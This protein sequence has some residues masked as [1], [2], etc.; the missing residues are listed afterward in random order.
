M[1]S[2]GLRPTFARAGLA[3]EVR[4]RSQ[5]PQHV[6]LIVRRPV[7]APKVHAGGFLEV[8]VKHEER[9]PGVHPF[10]GLDWLRATAML[11]STA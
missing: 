8:T 10:A 5:G 1:S 9:Q 11:V 6:G 3:A 4:Q 7:E 2:G